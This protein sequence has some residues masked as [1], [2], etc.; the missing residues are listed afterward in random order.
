MLSASFSLVL[1][2]IVF[3]PVCHGRPH[4]AGEQLIHTKDEVDSLLEKLVLRSIHEAS[5]NE[6]EAED[7]NEDEI[8]DIDMLL[9]ARILGA[10]TDNLVSISAC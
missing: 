6:L 9:L 1:L 2:A 7:E 8:D 3:T 10:Q 5:E 4:G